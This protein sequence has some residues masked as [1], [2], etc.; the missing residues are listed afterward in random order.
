MERKRSIFSY[1]RSKT[2]ICLHCNLFFR[3]SLCQLSFLSLSCSLIF[4]FSQLSLFSF[5]SLTV[6]LRKRNGTREIINGIWRPVN[7]VG[8]LLYLS[9]CVYTH[10]KRK[11]LSLSWNSPSSWRTHQKKICHSTRSKCEKTFQFTSFRILFSNHVF[12]SLRK[13]NI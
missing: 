10:W 6:E 11:Q 7:W 8:I 3:F 13:M 12:R 1:H 5:S 2:T 4:L 9:F